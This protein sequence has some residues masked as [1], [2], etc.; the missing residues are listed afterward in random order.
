LP[1]PTRTGYEFDGWFTSEN[2]GTKVEA[3]S[4]VE[5]T[6]AQTLYAQWTARNYTVSFNLNTGTGTAPKVITVTY[7][8]TYTSL[9][10]NSGSKTGYTFTGWYNAANGG[11]NISKESIVNTASNHILYAQWQA[12][13]YQVVFDANGGSGTMANQSCTYDEFQS[14]SANGFEKT[15]H[16]FSGWNTMSNGNG[17]S[18]EDTE[19]VTNLA[20]EGSITLY[21]KWTV[22]QYTISFDSNGG[23]AVS[24]ITQQSQYQLSRQRLVIPL[25]SGRKMG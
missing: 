6:S 22:K 25:A 20:T 8:G 9:P 17:T 4:K 24:P 21:A 13:T 15:G 1:T 12:N 19:E 7:D 18:Y 11:S 14:L 5:I 23:S 10:E 2:G 16:S 3:S